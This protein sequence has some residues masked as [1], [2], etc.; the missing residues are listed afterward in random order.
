MTFDF[1]DH[2]EKIFEQLRQLG[3]AVA[4]QP[5]SLSLSVSFARRCEELSD[6]LRRLLA[7]VPVKLPPP[8]TKHEIAV[9]EQF[10]VTVAKRGFFKS[11]F[12]KPREYPTPLDVNSR[13]YDEHEASFTVELP[14]PMPPGSGPR[15]FEVPVK[16]NQVRQ[17]ECDAPPGFEYELYSEE[18]VVRVDVPEVPRGGPFTAV[19][20][21]WLDR[22]DELEK[23]VRDITTFLKYHEE[24]VTELEKASSS[25]RADCNALELRVNQLPRPSKVE[26]RLEAIR[27][28][29]Q[30]IG[31]DVPAIEQ[32]FQNAALQ[33]KGLKKDFEEIGWDI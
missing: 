21:Q 24:K 16:R 33:L 30:R 14:E 3:D 7:D 12:G 25:L 20:Q 15:S 27:E 19:Q 2:I 13:Y 8:K 11:M 23:E 4:N 6:A 22:Y 9:S 26:D 31:E 28:E 29:L 32:Q 5:E 10:L 17:I 1:G 18:I